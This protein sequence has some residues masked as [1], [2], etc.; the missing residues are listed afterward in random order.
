MGID[1]TTVVGPYSEGD[2]VT[3]RCDVYGGRPLPTVSWFRDGSALVA[4]SKNMPLSNHLRSEIVLG[5]LSRQD[6]HSKLVCKASNHERAIAVEQSV[7][8]DMNCKLNL[9]TRNF[10]HQ[11]VNLNDSHSVFVPPVAPLNIRLIGSNQPLSAGHRYDLLCQ[12]AGSRPAAS[13]TWFLDG[14]RLDRSKETVML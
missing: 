11:N 13:I 6:L 12:S 14:I 5:P 7:Q 9:Y 10:V 4:E 1:R 3:L 8:I 2:I